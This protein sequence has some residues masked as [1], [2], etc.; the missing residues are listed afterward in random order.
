MSTDLPFQCFP[1][2]FK[3][4]LFLVHF[5]LYL[6]LIFSCPF[7]FFVSFFLSLS[8]LPLLLFLI[9]QF[10]ISFPFSVFGQMHFRRFTMCSHFF[11]FF[12][13]FFPSFPRRLFLVLVCFAYLQNSPA[14]SFFVF[15]QFMYFCSLSK[16]FC[17]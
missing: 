16:F 3:K 10:L 6:F 5:L 8:L 9:L 11:S 17:L 15:I 14:Q 12:I 7:F 2:L 1:R 4:S 13:P